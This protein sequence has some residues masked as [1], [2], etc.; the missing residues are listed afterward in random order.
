[1]KEAEIKK[2]VENTVSSFRKKSEMTL[3]LAE[4][5]S[6][7][8]LLKASSMGVK[9]VV[10]VSDSA[11]N[12]KVVKSM[13]DAYIASYDVALNKAFTSVA[14]KMSTYSLKMLAQPGESLY[15]I[16]FT[17]GGRIVIFGGGDTLCGTDGRIIGGLGVSGGTEEQDT[18]LSAYGKRYFETHM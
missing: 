8:V 10:C 6:N 2:I 9:A 13:D 7:E 16:Q 3:S 4:K 1:M 15:G 18:A 12:P 14:L 5:L 11:G 17:N